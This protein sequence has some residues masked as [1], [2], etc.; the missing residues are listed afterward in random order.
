MPLHSLVAWRDG[1]LARHADKSVRAHTV[2]VRNH[3][4]NFRRVRVADQCRGSQL[5]LALLIFRSKDVAQV[6]F[7]ALYFSCA[8]L[9]EALG[10]AFVCL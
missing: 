6:S 2:L 5:A 8:R 3:S 10:R 9:L 1:P 7:R 4:L